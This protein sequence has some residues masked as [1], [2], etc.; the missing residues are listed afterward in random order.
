MLTTPASWDRSEYGHGAAADAIVSAMT[1]L[2]F[3]SHGP[4][5]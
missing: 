5:E 2:S 4:G 3:L 1:G